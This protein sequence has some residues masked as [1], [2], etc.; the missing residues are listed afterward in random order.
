MKLFKKIFKI[1]FLFSFITVF[2]LTIF[3]I[4][5]KQKIPNIDEI[6]K[7][8]SEQKINILYNDGITPI[9]IKSNFWI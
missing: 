9:K 7:N 5:Y 1:T 4:Y 8:S 3:Y 6:I 2:V